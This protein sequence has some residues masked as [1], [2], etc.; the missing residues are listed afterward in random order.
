MVKVTVFG[1][2]RIFTLKLSSTVSVISEEYSLGGYMMSAIEAELI[3]VEQ[4]TSEIV[5]V[6]S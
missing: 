6:V 2:E 1:N 4:S 5:R 3:Y